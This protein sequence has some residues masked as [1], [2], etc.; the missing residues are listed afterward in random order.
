MVG[1]INYEMYITSSIVLALI[2]GSDT[3]FILG[4]SISN[5]RK[6]GIYSAL[7]ICSGILIHTFLAAFGLSVVLKNSI[8]AFNL[9]KFMGAI[10]LVYMGIK[11]IKSK[12][13]LLLNKGII[14]KDS[15]KK[16]FIQG[17]ITNILNPKVALFFLAFLP[18]FVDTTNSY[19]ALPFALLGL[20]SFFISGVWCVSL[21]LFASFIATFLK[22][23]KSFGKILNKISGIIFIILGV[24]LLRA[25]INS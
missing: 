15:L 9:V 3:M 6:A 21:S 23:N 2:P 24:N 18:Q 22:K 1:I 11:S 14:E 10:Y 16:A 19:G 4:Q 7:G 17:M 25:K 13:S 5:S 12:E 8:T 20:T